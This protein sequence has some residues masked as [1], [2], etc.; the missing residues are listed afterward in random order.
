MR[1][2]AGA[3]WAPAWVQLHFGGVDRLPEV[4]AQAAAN[5]RFGS[6]LL[7]NDFT[8]GAIEQHGEGGAGEKTR[9]SAQ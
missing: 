2:L 1:R 6:I 8:W 3:V 9:E 7:K 4:T 5:V